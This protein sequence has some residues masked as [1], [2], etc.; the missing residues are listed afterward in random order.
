MARLHETFST[1]QLEE[2]RN[3][4]TN[5]IVERNCKV[6]VHW[7]D[8]NENLVKDD[9]DRYGAENYPRKDKKQR[10]YIP[11]WLV[12]LGQPG[13]KRYTQSILEHFNE[14]HD[15]PKLILENPIVM[16]EI[17][18][19]SQV[20]PA[21]N[22]DFAL[23]HL[24]SFENDE[25]YGREKI[26][27]LTRSLMEIYSAA[28]IV[29]SNMKHVIYYAGAQ[30]IMYLIAILTSLDYKLV[31]YNEKKGECAPPPSKYKIWRFR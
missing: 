15:I 26:F 2:I 18:N 16:K 13:H 9:T 25:F 27:H 19:V 6:R 11:D 3:Y 28:R 23:H 14:Q 30:H 31:D 20:N 22:L 4:F 7:T 21:F 1:S 24:K 29:K 8:P 17:Q 12:Q 10:K 5:C